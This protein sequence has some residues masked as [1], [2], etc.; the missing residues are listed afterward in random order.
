MHLHGY[1]LK[2]SFVASQALKRG[3]RV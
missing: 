1:N 2:M 3:A